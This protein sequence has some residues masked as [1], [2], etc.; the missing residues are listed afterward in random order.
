MA[1][2]VKRKAQGVRRAANSRSR[3]SKARAAQR[4]SKGVVNTALSALPISQ[5]QLQ[6]GFLALILAGA[7]ALAYK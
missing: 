1:R 3:A 4:Q 7:A 2:K 6:G 5:K